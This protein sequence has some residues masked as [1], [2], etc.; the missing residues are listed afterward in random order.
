MPRGSDEASV[1]W[2]VFSEPCFS[3]LSRGRV[4]QGLRG[5][6]RTL[7]VFE[8]PDHPCHF[9][10][11]EAWVPK[12]EYWDPG[13]GLCLGRKQEAAA[14]AAH[15]VL[16]PEFQ[17]G[18]S[19]F[20]CG[21]RCSVS[22]PHPHAVLPRTPTPIHNASHMNTRPSRL[23]S[24]GA[25]GPGP[26]GI[27]LEPLVRATLEPSSSGQRPRLRELGVR[28][29]AW[30]MKPQLRSGTPFGEKS[31]VSMPHGFRGKSLSLRDPL[32]M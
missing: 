22:P 7:K 2:P 28:F 18:A 19:K 20:Q 14:L 13:C 32:P 9:A 15:H 30:E 3:T 16:T 12:A 23:C 11:R 6:C 25:A 8:I 4:G 21:E 10:K 31:G 26:P 17:L 5:F 27:E 24:V 1:T 29:R